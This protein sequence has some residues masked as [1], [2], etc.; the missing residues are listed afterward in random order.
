MLNSLCLYCYNKRMKHS[1]S[2]LVRFLMLV[3]DFIALIAAFTIAYIIRVE[4]SDRSVAESISPNTYIA[5]V[6]L[7]LLFWILVYALL[8]LYDPKKYESQFK[9]FS[10]L[11]VGSF[12]GIL[13]LMSAEYVLKQPIFPAKLVTVYGFLLGFS[14]TL[15]SRQ[16][17][18]ILRR[19]LYTRGIGVQNIVIIGSTQTTKEFVQLL[20]NPRYGYNVI[21]VVGDKRILHKGIDKKQQFST[22]AETIK[23]V[24]EPIHN[25]L[26]TDET[27]ASEN[28][29]LL[30]Y[31]EH[32]HTAYRFVPGQNRFY[33]GK[34]EMGLFK[35]VP[36]ISVYHTSL[37]GWSR[38]AK[39]LAD[40]VLSLVLIVVFSPLMLFLY[41]A[42]SVFDGG[43]A[44][45]KQKRLSRFK[46]RVNIYKFRSIKR[47]Y[48]GM[49]PEK[50]FAKM[51]QPE[52]AKKYRS[53]GDFLEDDPRIDSIGKFLRDTSLDELPQ[54]FNVLKGDL[55]L[56]GPRPLVPKELEAYERHN[57]ILSVKP[58]IT[59]LAAV[60]GRR[61]LSFE[62]R[63]KLDVYYVQ[64]WSLWLD[65]QILVKTVV[66]VVTRKGAR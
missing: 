8:G 25:I 1:A 15:L 49:S 21:A 5:T 20:Q 66:V 48:S 2:L 27:T 4:I 11:L 7:L 61:N 56:V 18:K 40:I 12:I 53:N 30:D 36:T 41:V 38:I 13:F 14:F 46:T 34:V 55:S 37:T 19:E 44:L 51:K 52:L 16:F 29:L 64:N 54:L 59:G 39:R 58:G 63:R 3:G 10:L 32:N 42:L 28:D 22:F 62:E 31:A 24:K 43:N 23:K 47:E 26:Q 6:S 60:S 65:L 57:L 50:A 17:I 35:G 45:Y 33:E 9:E